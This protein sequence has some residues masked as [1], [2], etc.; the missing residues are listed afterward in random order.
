MKR[1]EEKVLSHLHTKKE[2][3]KIN[4][5]ISQKLKP[6]GLATGKVRPEPKQD[7]QTATPSEL[8]ENFEF[9]HS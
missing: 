9:L 2:K 5:K 1:T 3:R 6:F 4:K 7:T 8:E